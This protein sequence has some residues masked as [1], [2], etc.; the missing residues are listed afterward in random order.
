MASMVI[1]LS[2]SESETIKRMNSIIIL[3]L[4]LITL[5]ICSLI[6][7]SAFNL[8]WFKTV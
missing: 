2:I 8:F 7:F 5:F 3:W 6:N 1:I 4:P